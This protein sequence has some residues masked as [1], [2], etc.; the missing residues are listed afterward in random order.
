MITNLWGRLLYYLDLAHVKLIQV[1]L[2]LRYLPL[3]R[4]PVCQGTGGALGY[5]EGGSEWN[6]CSFCYQYWERLEFEYDA[7]WAAGR[8]PPGRLPWAWLMMKTGQYTFRRWALCHFGR[9]QNMDGAD[10]ICCCCY[11]EIESPAAR[12]GEES[13]RT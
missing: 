2:V 8:I 9:H 1:G 3:V 4:C 11:S 6:E 7:T 10:G 13:K 12:M 5:Y